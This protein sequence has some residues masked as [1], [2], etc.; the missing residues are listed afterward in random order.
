M[1][2]GGSVAA[3]LAEYDRRQG[4]PGFILPTSGTTGEPKGVVLPQN[5]C[6]LGPLAFRKQGQGLKGGP[7]YYICLSWGHGVP[8]MQLETAFWLGGSA[9]IAKGF[10]ASG[11]WDD[12]DAHHC[13]HAFGMSTMLRMLYNTDLRDR[14]DKPHLDMITSGL[15]GDMWEGFVG[16]YNVSVHE[17]YGA[18]DLCRDPEKNWLMNP[19]QYPVGSVGRPMPRLD[20][21]LVDDEM[22]DVS[23]GQSG[24]LVA[25]PNGSE[26]VVEYYNDPEASRAKVHDGWSLSGDLF[27]RDE[28]GNFWYVGRQ[29]E[30][31]RRNAMNISPVEVERTLVAIP[32]VRTT[33]VFA[34]PSELAEDEIKAAVIVSNPELTADAVAEAARPLVPRHMMP[35]YFEIV[36]SIPMTGSG[37]AQRFMM[38]EGWRTPT[39]WDAREGA[40]LDLADA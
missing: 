16:R 32:G 9:V 40:Y 27:R 20:V 7:K 13:T 21:R 4:D 28:E 6:L 34:V 24:Q 31:I 23:V 35:R 33:I 5:W 14:S 3:H 17:Q 30:S 26:A 29:T 22:K 10:S 15:P 18:T 19:G 11:F 2:H 1:N 8:L 38:R 36:D 12:V 37:K 25:R 39:T